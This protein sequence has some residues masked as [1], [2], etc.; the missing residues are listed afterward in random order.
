MTISHPSDD[1]GLTYEVRGFPDLADL[2]GNEVMLF[3]F[4]GAHER[5][6]GSLVVSLSHVEP[7]DEVTTTEATREVRAALKRAKDAANPQAHAMSALALALFA[8]QERVIEGLG[9]IDDALRNTIGGTP[10]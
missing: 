7:A 10:R 3:R 2:Y 4:M 1:L 6:D 8:G 9:E 5:A